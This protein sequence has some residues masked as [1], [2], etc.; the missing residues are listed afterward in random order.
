MFP[1]MLM[2]YF[3]AL[4]CYFPEV[5]FLSVAE[6]CWCSD[7]IPPFWELWLMPGYEGS[8]SW[9]LC[10]SLMQPISLPSLPGWAFTHV[11]SRMKQCLFCSVAPVLPPDAIRSPNLMIIWVWEDV[12]RGNG[13]LLCLASEPLCFL[14]RPKR[15]P[16]WCH[17]AL[18]IYCII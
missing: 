11:F 15:V 9:A 12:R 8:L 2:L 3:Q 5:F 18:R 4:L 14:W 16:S 7:L 6:G 10:S 1:D 17:T 13:S